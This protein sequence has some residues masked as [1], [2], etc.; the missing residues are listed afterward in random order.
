MHGAADFVQ[1]V[2]KLGRLRERPLP[3]MAGGMRGQRVGSHVNHRPIAVHRY[4]L[5]G[6]KP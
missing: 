4:L 3:V 2:L 1:D 6:V 5:I